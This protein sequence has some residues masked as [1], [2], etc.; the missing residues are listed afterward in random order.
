MATWNHVGHHVADLDRSIR[1]YRGVFGFEELQRM[2]IPDVAAS[3][4]LRVPRPVGLTAVYLGLDGTVLELLHFER[5]GNE[6]AR[7]RPFTEPGLTHMSFTV[8]DV[9]ATCAA[10]IDHGGA[11]LT[12]TDMGGLAVLVGDPD[13]QVLELL[14]PGAFTADPAGPA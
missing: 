6:P 2:E 12:D 8:D 7:V 1:F 3:K 10:V 4:L 14:A 9:A 11:V 5:P 13:G